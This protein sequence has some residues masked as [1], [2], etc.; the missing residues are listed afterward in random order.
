LSSRLGSFGGRRGRGCGSSG[1]DGNVLEAGDVGKLGRETGK[2]GLLRFDAFED[3]IRGGSA[4]LAGL[5]HSETDRG[6]EKE[7]AEPGREFLKDVGGVGAESGVEG[8]AA[9]GRAETFLLGTL[10]QDDE[11]HQDTDRDDDHR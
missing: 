1:L 11:H 3:V 6:D 9:K 8:T 2:L 4:E 10:D 7:N 5:H